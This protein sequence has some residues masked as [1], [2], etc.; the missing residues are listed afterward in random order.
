MA[1]PRTIAL[2][3]KYHSP[4]IAE[5]LRSLGQYLSERGVSVLVEADTAANVGESRWMTGDFLFI[6][7]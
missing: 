5:S 4:E 7:A 2:I 6:G 1:L 3:G